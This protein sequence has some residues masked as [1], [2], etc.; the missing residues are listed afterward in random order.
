MRRRPAAVP[1]RVP[2]ARW[3]SSTVN[4]RSSPAA[5][6]GSA[7]RRA[8]AWPPRAHASRS[9]TSTRTRAA[10][11]ADSIDGIACA[12]DVTDFDALHAA[13]LDAHEQLGGLTLLFN[14]AGGSSMAGDPR[15]GPRRVAAHRHAEPHRRV[16][17]V[18]GGRAAHP[19]SPAAARSCR[20][21]RSR[22]R[23]RRPAKRRTPRPRPR[24]PRSPR[25]P[26]SSTRR[27]S[28]STRCRPG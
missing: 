17:R 4:A 26:R 23:D 5:R 13:A 18:Q 10:E 16:P 14:N 20:P 22:A 7:R 9:S 21:R 12:V 3:V 25:R 11:V 6:R 28:A 19:R 27:R 1:A 24:S 8:G 2:F 15:L